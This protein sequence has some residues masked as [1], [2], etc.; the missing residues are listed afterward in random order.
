MWAT[1]DDIGGNISFYGIIGFGNVDGSSPTLRYWNG[2]AWTNLST[3]ISYNAWTSFQIVINGANIEYWVNGSLVGSEPGNSSVY[4][5]E[6]IMQAY[7]FNDPSLGVSYDASA[8]NSYDAFWDNL[9]VTGTG[10]NVVENI[11]QSTLHCSIQDAVDNA[12]NGDVIEASAGTYNETV[13]VNVDVTI[14]GANDGIDP[15]TGVRGA[16][17]IVEN[18]GFSIP[19]GNT[20]TI[21]GF[22]IYNTNTTTPVSL[23]GSSVSTVQY[24]IIERDGAVSGS[25]IRGIEISNGPGAKVVSNNLFTGDVSGGLFSGHVSWNSGMYVNGPLAGG[26]TI[27]DNVFENCRTA[28]NLD[29]YSASFT[30]SGNTFD[31]NGT[32]ASFGGAS[33]TS[34]SFTW[35][36]NEFGNPGSAFFNLSNVTTAFRLDV[37]AGTYQGSSFASYP[38]ATLFGIESGMYHRGRS[39]RNGLVT[40]VAGNQYV[41]QLNPSIQAA[42]DYAATNHVIHVQDGTYSERVTI[43]LPVKID[44]ESETG[45][46]LDGTGLPGTG[47]GIHILTGVTDVTIQDMT[48]KNFAGAGPNSFAGIYGQGQNSNLT[49]QHVT[50]KDN[51]GGSGFYANGPV[52][53]VTLDDLEVS[54]HTN[55]AG[56]ARGI[57]I[58]NGLKSNISITNCEVFNNNCC[59]IELQDG[60]ATGVTMNNNLVHDNGDNGIGIVGL[61]GPG[62]NTIAGNT[63][64]DNGR[65]G[66]EI[67]NPNGSGASSGP[68]SI[69]VDNNTVSRTTAIGDARDI[70]GI[71][72]FRRGVLAGNV[73]V[74][75]GVFIQNNAVS[76]YQQTS[77]SDGFGIVI[78]GLNHTVSGNNLFG[79]DVGVQQQA[80]HLPY[81]GDGDQ[82]NLADQYFGRGN[83]PIS[84]GNT[85]SGNTFSSNGTDERSVGLTGGLVTNVNTGAIFCSIQA[86]IDAASTLDGHTLTVGAGTFDEALN[87]YKSLTILGPNEAQVLIPEPGLR[88]LFWPLRLPMPRPSQVRQQIKS[89]YLRA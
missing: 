23:G 40:Y 20:V 50:I 67:K 31:N 14:R 27:T 73:D 12:N 72:A 35:G 22:H 68:G 57:V 9:V 43:D 70:A 13:L 63:V 10:G 3:S 84:C 87:I 65:F 64:T 60:T 6:V 77:S 29:D 61:E 62:T 79:N 16:E 86:A 26:M 47:R 45:T 2:A 71:A 33:P 75:T 69:L 66:I 34:G 49:I 55:V 88:K 81:P 36:A 51:L 52:N 28:M 17:S 15:N 21:D 59:G 78:E 39:G 41:I 32:H 85:I 18:G 76:G 74:P 4:F 48:V 42:V 25:P 89:L 37:S 7:N 30:V 5:R 24:C 46:M 8:N 1:A 53:N 82:S 19:G 83:S 58:W 38:L 80:G 54:G 56:A 11:T 44:G